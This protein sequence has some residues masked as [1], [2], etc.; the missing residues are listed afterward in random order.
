MAVGY[1]IKVIASGFRLFGLE[2]SILCRTCWH[3]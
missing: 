1:L 3:V 2:L